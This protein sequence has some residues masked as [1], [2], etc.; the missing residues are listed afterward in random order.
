[1]LLLR[2]THEASCFV[3]SVIAI[4]VSLHFEH[5]TC[6]S[7][8]IPLQC[9]FSNWPPG[10]HRNVPFASILLCPFRT[11]WYHFARTPVSLINRISL[12][13]FGSS[14]SSSLLTTVKT[15]FLVFASNAI[16][17]SDSSEL[18]GNLC[19]NPPLGDEVIQAFQ[20]FQSSENK[21]KSEK[22]RCKTSKDEKRSIARISF[23]SNSISSCSIGL[24]VQ[25]F[26]FPHLSICR[27]AF[28]S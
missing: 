17:A 8:D 4:V 28:T 15:A 7:M 1:M 10:T 19:P 25:V 27:E 18:P 2:A 3:D 16:L 24:V 23:V 14:G 26:N 5:P 9:S 13:S 6:R 21:F 20:E 22:M 12:N 11:V